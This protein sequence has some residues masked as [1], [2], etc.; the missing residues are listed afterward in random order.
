M[1]WVASLGMG[2]WY[3][4]IFKR[5]DRSEGRNDREY[6]PEYPYLRKPVPPCEEKTKIPRMY[7]PLDSPMTSLPEF[8]RLVFIGWN[9]HWLLCLPEQ[10]E[11]GGSLHP[12]QQPGRARATA[13]VRLLTPSL[14]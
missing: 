7:K 11:K 9:E 12:G 6:Q 2:V 5:S 1:D 14:P 10:K 13:L 4:R 3:Y 8:F